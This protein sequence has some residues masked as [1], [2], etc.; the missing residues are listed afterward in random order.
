M[1][2]K[3]N[4]QKKIRIDT[5]TKKIAS[6]M[7][8]VVGERK[9][10]KDAMRELLGLTDFEQVK[11]RDLTLYVRPLK[12]NSK[13][14]LVFDNELP[15]YHSTTSDVAMRKTPHWKEMFSISNVIKILNDKDVV[16]SKGKESLNRV[17]ANA[18]SQLD[19]SYSRDDLDAL[20][21]DAQISLGRKSLA[22]LQESLDLFFELLGF[23]AVH[24]E[25]EEPDIRVF[26]R[27]KATDE[28]APLYEDIVVLD[29]RNVEV[30]L[31]K[32]ELH[33]RSDRDMARFLQAVRGE[34]P[35][36]AQGE[37]VFEYLVELGIKQQKT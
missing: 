14:V 11:T 37:T 2:L 33:P 22:D 36:D 6:T 23:Q 3:E 12:E 1:S 26:A 8:E 28:E 31:M 16:V 34:I 18:L 5:L 7:R 27:I 30:R 35:P 4:L 32:G 17:R 21:R 9:L 13:E 19:M 29:E 25:I 20:L 10:D 15:I 24:L